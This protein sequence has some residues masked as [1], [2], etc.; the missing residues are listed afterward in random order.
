LEREKLN[1]LN[2]TNE[3]KIEKERLKTMRATIRTVQDIVGNFLNNLLLFRIEAEETKALSSDSLSLLD[4]LTKETS[5]KINEIGEL[6]SIENE[7]IAEGMV[8]IK[9][10]KSDNKVAINGLKDS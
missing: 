8:G 5:S 4:S 1:A 7:K 9:L 2:A 6:N 10:E 3:L